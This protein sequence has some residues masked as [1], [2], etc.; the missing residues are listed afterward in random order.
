MAEYGQIIDAGKFGKWVTNPAGG[1]LPYVQTEQFGG[2]VQ[3]GQG[4]FVSYN[5]AVTPPTA[6]G[7]QPPLNG[8]T[9]PSGEMCFGVAK[10]TAGLRQGYEWFCNQETRAWDTRWV[11]A[12]PEPTG[13]NDPMRNPNN[14]PGVA[15]EGFRYQWNGTFWELIKTD[16]PKTDGSAELTR[17]RQE[18]ARDLIARRLEAYGL[19]NLGNFVWD[20]ISKEN[21]TSEYALV[22][23]IR[24]TDQYKQRFPA[25]AM[26]RGAGLNA[27][28]EEEYVS[29]EKGY[30]QVLKIAGMP[31]NLF[32]T[33]EDFTN[34]IGGDVSVT[35]LNQ[36]VQQGYQAVAQSNPQVIN[37]MKRLYGIDDAGLAAYFL[38][39]ERAT[40]VLLRQARAAQIAAEGTLQAGMEVTGAQAEQLAVAGVSQEAA[41]QGFQ[42]IAG[43]EELFVPLPGTTE[44]AISQEE[45]IA[46][47]FGTQ[48]AAQQRVRQR[49]RERAAAFQAGGRFAGQGTTVTGLQ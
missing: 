39:P 33:P 27:I 16:T 45:Q 20:L 49:A 17:A 36:R 15:P 42:T 10:P 6:G 26:R 3:T 21:I 18:S 1:F 32:D 12:G 9:Q 4:Q 19:G 23:R 43:A 11:G 25:M 7:P 40:P 46:G 44:Q 13:P 28:S 48:A 24:E 35:E 14:P 29:L 31:A 47:V 41:R 37:E 38:A 5:P 22:E 30:R 2:F 8:T 34:L